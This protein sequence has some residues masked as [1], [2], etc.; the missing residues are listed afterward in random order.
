MF[1]ELQIYILLY[2]FLYVI[3]ISL[4][5]LLLYN[6]SSNTQ[7]ALKYNKYFTYNYKYFIY[8]LCFL[9]IIISG[10]PPFSFFFIKTMYC[11]YILMY[12]NFIYFIYFI[13]FILIMLYF[14]LKFIQ[15]FFPSNILYNY[16]FKNFK[17]YNYKLNKISILFIYLMLFFFIY[18]ND[19]FLI[20]LYLINY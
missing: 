13:Y 7:Y 10:I 12:T 14:Y 3:S 15:L 19:C 6:I 18:L 20:I 8:I 16:N 17:L 9:I 1:T 11:K 5:T 2:I 4:F